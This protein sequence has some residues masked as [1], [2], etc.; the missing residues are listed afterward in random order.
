MPRHKLCSA[1]LLACCACAPAAPAG[2]TV[3]CGVT[4]SGVAFGGYDVFS[5]TDLDR[6]GTL[7]VKCDLLAD[8]AQDVPYTLSLS[9]G[10]SGSYSGRAMTNLMIST[11]KMKYNLYTTSARN[12]VWGD[13]TGGSITQGGTI[14]TLSSGSPSQSQD[15]SVYGRITAGQD[16]AVGNYLDTVV[17]TVSF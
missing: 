4:T 1:I 8:P 11:E 6:T 10:G 16:V 15:W 2:A 5:G 9:A 17:V 14:P 7:T 12:V 13:G 3:S